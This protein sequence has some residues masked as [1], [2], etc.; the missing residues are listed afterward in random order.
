MKATIRTLGDFTEDPYRPGTEGRYQAVYEAR[1][2]AKARAQMAE[3]EAAFAAALG[4]AERHAAGGLRP[5]DPSRP[6]LRQGRLVAVFDML[7][8]RP[9]REQD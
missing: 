3:D 8:L 1:D 4:K 2:Q 6:T 7:D 5:V 9:W